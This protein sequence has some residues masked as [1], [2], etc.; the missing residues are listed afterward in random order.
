MCQLLP[1]GPDSSDNYGSALNAPPVCS[2]ACSFDRSS[3]TWMVSPT[4]EK[5]LQ[6]RE[7][8]FTRRKGHNSTYSRL[9][10]CYRREFFS[11][12]VQ[13][14][15]C[16]LVIGNCSTLTENVQPFTATFLV[17]SKCSE[18]LTSI[19][20]KSANK[21]NFF[22]KRACSDPLKTYCTST[23]CEHLLN[24][25]EHKQDFLCSGTVRLNVILC[26]MFYRTF[27]LKKKKHYFLWA[28]QKGTILI[29]PLLLSAYC[30]W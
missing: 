6:F 17:L 18:R 25:C 22:E 12:K 26:D 11:R 2:V 24:M 3:C 30:I 4:L 13:E 5:K 9:R 16:P 27:W 8:I 23:V 21:N 7:N 19:R 29:K 1:G 28:S 15:G 10:H 20:R 14:G